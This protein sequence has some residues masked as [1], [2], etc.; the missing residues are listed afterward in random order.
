MR[1]STRWTAILNADWHL[2]PLYTKI[3]TKK[4]CALLHVDYSSLLSVKHEHYYFISWLFMHACCVCKYRMIS[5]RHDALRREFPLK[6]I[7]FRLLPWIESVF[8]KK[9]DWISFL[10]VRPTHNTQRMTIWHIFGM[11]INRTKLVFFSWTSS[12]CRFFSIR[13]KA[14]IAWQNK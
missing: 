12:C 5:C 1:N 4:N 10:V 9:L 14:C 7:I 6:K 3:N 2:L 8:Q 11:L 13:Y